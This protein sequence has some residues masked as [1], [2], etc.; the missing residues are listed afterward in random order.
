[1]NNLSKYSP[2][3]PHFLSSKE[4]VLACLI[5]ILKMNES[6]TRSLVLETLSVFVQLENGELLSFLYLYFILS[7]LLKKKKNLMII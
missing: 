5:K 2:S 7:S 4:S 6:Q 3:I 1:M